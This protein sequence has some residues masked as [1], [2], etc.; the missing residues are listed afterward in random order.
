MERI[1]AAT[2]VLKYLSK[3]SF[4]FV[5]THDIELQ[6][7]LNDEFEM[8]HFSE[9]VDN[10]NFYFDYKIKK[11]PCSSRNAIKLLELKGYPKEIT[12]R[13]LKLSK[14]ITTHVNGN[15]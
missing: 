2:S 14:T 10:G 7:L 11:G 15:K 13:A 12:D 3:Y 1:S 6:E 5:T 8:Y 4:I 9:Q